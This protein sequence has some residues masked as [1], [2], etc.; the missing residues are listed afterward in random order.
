[1]RELE[2]NIANDKKRLEEEKDMVESERQKIVAEL[3]KKE[4]DL[5]IAK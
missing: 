3:K 1:M 5:I 2:L 4:D